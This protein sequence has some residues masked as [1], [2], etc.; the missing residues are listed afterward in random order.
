MICRYKMLIVNNDIEDCDN[1]YCD[2]NF[3]DDFEDYDDNHDTGDDKG[4]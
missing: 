1:D 4:T 2:G 3:N